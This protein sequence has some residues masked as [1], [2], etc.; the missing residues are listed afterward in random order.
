MCMTEVVT[1][2]EDLLDPEFFSSIA[3]LT[4]PILLAALGGSICHRAGVFN[5]ALEGFIL[6]GA[7]MAVLGSFFGGSAFWGALSALLGGVFL[8]LVFAEFHLRRRGDPIVVSIAINLLGLGLS[9][10]L[11]RSIFDVS[12]VFSHPNIHKLVTIDWP[13]LDSVW[14]LDLVFN[15][16]SILFYLAILSVI[17]LHYF[18]KFHKLGLWIR[19][20]GENQAALRASGT[21]PVQVK[22]L[23]LIMCGVLCGLAGAQLSISNVGLFVENMSAG[24][25]W[26]AVVVVLLCA[27]RPIPLFF[28]I[29]LFGIVDSLSLRI[30]GFGLPQQITEMMPY[31]VSILVL[32][33]VS[34]RRLR[35]SSK[36]QL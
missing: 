17:A 24:R 4:T 25:G 16:Q 11:L 8:A 32:M 35:S 23:A 28:L 15:D 34:F 31:V 7:F 30:Q 27:G 1:M 36:T 2:I 5:I 13:F 22:L 18:L 6:L 19:A 9:T 12:G 29:I 10:Y 14:F 3:R 21:N 26:I 20:A 33:F